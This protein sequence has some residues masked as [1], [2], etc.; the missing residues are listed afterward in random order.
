MNEVIKELN[1]I[2]GRIPQQTYK[3][4]IGQVRAGDIGG[5]TVGINR[6][7]HKLARE[8]AAHGKK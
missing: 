6:L 4:I 1:T 3:T 5:A 8:E 2:K 7:K